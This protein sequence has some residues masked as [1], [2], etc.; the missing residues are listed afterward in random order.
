MTK[1]CWRCRR[2]GMTGFCCRRRTSWAQ[3]ELSRCRAVSRYQ[4]SRQ[5]PSGCRVPSCCRMSVQCRRSRSDSTKGSSPMVDKDTAATS[6]EKVRCKEHDGELHPRPVTSHNLV[7]CALAEN[8]HDVVRCSSFSGFI[9][10]APAAT[11]TLSVGEHCHHSQSLFWYSCSS[12]EWLAGRG[13]PRRI[14]TPTTW[15][16]P[17]QCSSRREAH[18]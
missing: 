18:L 6:V 8:C 17:K 11:T 10:V 3:A 12:K 13:N 2:N 4:S 1:L 7:R 15:P 14:D 16:K 9:V 5:D